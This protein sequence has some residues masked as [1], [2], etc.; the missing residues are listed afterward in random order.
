[1]WRKIGGGVVLALALAAGSWLAHQHLYLAPQLARSDEDHGP[2]M[3][4][5]EGVHGDE[6]PQSVKI[7]PQARQNLG[8][9][10]QPA[11]LTSYWRTLDVPGRIIDRPGLSDHGITAPVSGVVTRM[12]AFPGDMVEPHAPLFTIQLASE[13]LHAS[14]LELFQATKEIAIVR[15][16]LERLRQAAASGALPQARLIELE[17]QLERLQATVQAHQQ[18]L[19]SRGLPEDQIE[20]AARGEFA[21]QFTVRA[22]GEHLHGARRMETRAAAEPA[23]PFSFEMQA[24][25][26][27][28]GQHV[29]AGSLLC[30]LA[31][32]RELLI[33]GRAFEH[34]MPWLQTAAQEGWEIE[35]EFEGASSGHWPS[36]PERLKIRH[37]ANTVDAET[38]TFAFFLPLENQWRLYEHDGETRLLWRFRPGNRVRLRVPVERFEDVFVLPRAAVV[39]DGPDAFVFR[40]NGQMFD[41][42]PVH[43][44]HEDRRQ[45]VIA[46]DGGL[47]P[48]FYVALQGAA[49][50]QR[51]LKSQASD[52]LP[53]GMHMHAD[54]TIHGA[55]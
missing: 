45:A 54:G 50:L 44:M 25:A 22:L 20:A 3:H 1:M 29:E 4:G 5:G 37:L 42:L 13:T 10:T 11:R 17:N 51:V 48:H 2:I 32:H 52:G 47:R 49:A 7:S 34:D 19:R 9:A 28:L 12:F 14:Q 41:R 16:Q 8:L 40:Q 6:G 31:D 35:V 27:E 15:Q 26:V 24:L 18:H 53:P 21:T 55:H 30:N 38:R 46:K 39:R 43:V 33:E 23:A 36:P